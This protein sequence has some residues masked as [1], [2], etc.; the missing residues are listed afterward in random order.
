MVKICQILKN[1]IKVDLLGEQKKRL[2]I[3]SKMNQIFLSLASFPQLN[4]LIH[5][6]NLKGYL[7][8]ICSKE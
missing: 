6:Y 5:D 8:G 4:I 3:N 2:L 1:S 7:H